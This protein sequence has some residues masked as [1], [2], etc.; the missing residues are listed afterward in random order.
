MTR[1]RN[2][3]WGSARRCNRT[4]RPALES[5]GCLIGRLEAWAGGGCPDLCSYPIAA[6]REDW[7]DGR[8]LRD[9]VERTHRYSSSISKPFIPCLDFSRSCALNY[10]SDRHFRFSLAASRDAR[11][12]TA[13]VDS[14]GGR[15]LRGSATPSGNGADHSVAFDAGIQAIRRRGRAQIVAN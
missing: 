10:E 14:K 8:T 11:F 15:R 3:P 13:A 2:A 7:R 4:V 1:F 9:G 6:S 5:T 12:T